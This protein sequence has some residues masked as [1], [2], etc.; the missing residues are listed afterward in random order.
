MTHQDGSTKTYALNEAYQILNLE[1]SATAVNT[2]FAFDDDGRCT[3]DSRHEYR[4][5][6]RGQLFEVRELSTGEVLLRQI[7]DPL[8]RVVKR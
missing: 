8:G 2:P 6:A 1:T 5:D 3:S 4:Y 7:F